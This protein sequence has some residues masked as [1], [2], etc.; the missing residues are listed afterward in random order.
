MS[1]ITT[2]ANARHK[3]TNA[4]QDYEFHT[5]EKHFKRSR[6]H[7]L[8]TVQR[9]HPISVTSNCVEMVKHQ[10]VGLSCITDLCSYIII[11]C[12][13]REHRGKGGS[14]TMKIKPPP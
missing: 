8:D 1:R 2:T 13:M 11:C 10:P 3:T 9:H 7:L 5:M 12:L 6:I 4:S 14:S